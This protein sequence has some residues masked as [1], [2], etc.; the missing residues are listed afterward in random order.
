MVS[1]ILRLLK[2]LIARNGGPPPTRA[3]GRRDPSA[4]PLFRYT[5]QDRLVEAL[6]IAQR[7]GRAGRLVHDLCRSAARD[8]RRAGVSEGE[9]MRLCGWETR[10]MFDRYNIIDEAD[11]GA[12][13]ARRF[14]NGKKPQT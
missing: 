13:V 14:G 7:A 9:I 1:G 12:A 4:R 2:D 5:A 6:R 10:S 11:L 3:A 8:I